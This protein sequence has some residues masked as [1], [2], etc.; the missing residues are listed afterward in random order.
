M[1]EYA[2][3]S[4]SLKKSE[5]RP[6]PAQERAIRHVSGPAQV[7]AGP[8]SGK[9]HVTVQRIRYL[10]THC[11]AE[12]SHIL[13]ITFTK[14]AA[15]EMQERF[16]RLMAPERPPVRFGTFHA[17]FYHILRQ[18]P[19]YRDYSIITESERRKLFRQIIRMH[20]R[21]ANVQ[22]EDLA[23]VIA[24]ADA[25]RGK[26]QASC[27]QHLSLQRLDGEDIAFLNR[28]YEAYLREFGQMDFDGIGRFCLS[29]LREDPALLAMWQAQFAY[30]L[31]DEFQDISPG[32]Y[33]IMRLLAAP[34]NNLFIV[35]DDDQ[36]IYGFRGASPDSMQAFL[37][38][39]PEAERIFL[40]VN[41][42]CGGTIVE[43]AGRVIAEN[44][45]RVAKEIRAAHAEG[46][47]FRLYIAEEEIE[48]ERYLTE[49]LRGKQQSGEL[50]QCALICRTNYGCALWA[51]RLHRQGIPYVLKEAPGNPFDHFVVRDIMAYLALAE[52]DDTRR[53]FFRIMN[54]PVRYLRR[55]SISSERVCREEM[56]E[57]YRD[58]P[59]LQEAVRRLFQDLDSLR[60][61]KPHLQIRYIR[62]V[63]GYDG[64]LRDKYGAEKAEELL[65]TAEDFQL[66]AERFPSRRAIEDYISQC[67]EALQ[68]RNAAK[69][70][71]EDEKKPDGLQLMTMHAAKGLEFDCVYLPDC[72]EG[73]IPYAK[74]KTEAQI[75]EERRM[76]YVAMTRAKKELCV[77]AWQGKSGKDAP[78]RFLSCLCQSSSSP[79]SSSN[80]A[81]SRYSSK[82]SA[83]ASY[84][85]S[86]SMYASSGSSFASSG[87]SL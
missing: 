42:R 58:A 19:Q 77:T 12:P 83:T 87:F 38:D 27:A 15:L 23:E 3:E 61:K 13:V 68:K 76:F 39:Y 1:P 70:R 52:G 11:G 79:T 57:Y 63:I 5:R 8:G 85:S 80:S 37:R 9:T 31:I 6:D 22:E 48:Q 47:G 55:E 30:I 78:S 43:A 32:Q 25:C 71:T 4:P 36:S 24:C 60:G 34:E 81:A 14:A 84:S 49:A 66:L 17:V 20:K 73:K 53:S 51:Q 16:F 26:P 40:D 67:G 50:A 45:S 10:I 72:Q 18:S 86:S 35:G 82:A 64:Y 56:M 74:S 41:Y 7:F 33:E 21:F 44:R 65:R 54:R 75:E 28:E 29:L 59:A 2:G 69:V 46:A 62:K